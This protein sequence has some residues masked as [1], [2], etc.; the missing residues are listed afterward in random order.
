VAVV[1]GAA[2]LGI[3]VATGLGVT[4]ADVLGLTGAGQ[5][6]SQEGTARGILPAR[7]E[8]PRAGRTIDLTARPPLPPAVP[9]VNPPSADPSA[10][11]PS[12]VAAAPGA[13]EP[14]TAPDAGPAPAP[15]RTVRTGDSCAAV[16]RTAV[17]GKGDA[18]VCTA[19]PGNGPNKWRVA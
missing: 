15:V 2:V 11:Q 4:T 13:D 7:E 16:G 18:A 10:E 14:A 12:P 6:A 19:S 17:T 8:E 1:L 9:E 5:V 3:V